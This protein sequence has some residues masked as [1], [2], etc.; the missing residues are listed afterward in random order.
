MYQKHMKGWMQHLDFMALD[1]LALLIAFFFSYFFRH[2][3]KNPFVV[4][5]YR[6]MAVFLLSADIILMLLTA[7]FENILKRKKASNK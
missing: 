3:G 2:G 7:P 1:L 4:P 5:L 6:N